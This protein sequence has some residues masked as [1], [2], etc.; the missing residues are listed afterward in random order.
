MRICLL[1]R[2]N[3]VR[4][5]RV[6]RQAKALS[7]A[8]HEVT[9]CSLSRP[10]DELIQT[11]PCVEYHE[12]ELLPWTRRPLMKVKRLQAPNRGG[13]RSARVGHALRRVGWL[14]LFPFWFLLVTVPSAF[15]LRLPGESASDRIREFAAKPLRPVE[16]CLQ[17][18]SQHATT[19]SFGTR[20]CAAL[21]GRRFDYVQAHDSYALVAAH[22]LARQSGA[23]LVFDAVEIAE[24]RQTQVDDRT[25][26]EELVFRYER[27]VEAGLIRRADHVLTIGDRLAD[28]HARRYRIEHPVVVRNARYFVEHRPEDEIRRDC[29]LGTG[30]KLVVWVGNLDPVQ[31]LDAIIEAA[32][33]IP[34]SVHFAFIGAFFPVHEKFVEAL[35]QTVDERGLAPRIHFFDPRDPNELI[36]Y[37]SG[38]DMGIIPRRPV[39]LNVQY[40]LPNKVME[41][42]MARLPLAAN[43]GLVEVSSVVEDYG[44][45]EVFDVESRDDLVRAVTTVLEDENLPRYREAVMAAAEDLRWEKEVLKYLALFEAAPGR[46]LS[47]QHAL[48]ALAA[49]RG[50]SVRRAKQVEDLRATLKET[51]ERHLLLKE[52]QHQAIGRL[53]A[54]LANSRGGLRRTQARTRELNE[55]LTKQKEQYEGSLQRWREDRERLQARMLELKEAFSRRVIM[56]EKA[57]ERQRATIDAAKAHIAELKQALERQKKA[58]A[59][60]QAAYEATDLPLQAD[61]SDTGRRA[62]RGA[63]PIARWKPEEIEELEEELLEAPEAMY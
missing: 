51:A 50:T 25:P 21:K 56:L 58:T 44:L 42:I 37:A 17:I 12:I 61:L 28:W 7:E 6:L 20:T 62:A 47:T 45:G 40:C 52:R 18:L 36:R 49:E 13:E 59:A 53:R 14:F 57:V 39:S 29:G 60:A 54:A 41:M 10:G 9:V 5:T 15:L 26:F 46:E 2:Y 35:R 27:R 55:A 43:A 22:R 11:T 48:R 38:G 33:L 3:L 31:G 30:D 34:E 63:L 16:R 8:G 1:S 24:H 32:P 4:N 23:K 19:V